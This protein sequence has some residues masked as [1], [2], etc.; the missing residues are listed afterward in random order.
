MGQLGRTL[1]WDILPIC[2][3]RGG[4]YIDPTGD[5]GIDE[6]PYRTTLALT[7]TG[8]EMIDF[9]GDLRNMG[10]KDEEIEKRWKALITILTLEMIPPEKMRFLIAEME[11]SGQG[12][13]SGGVE[14]QVLQHAGT[15]LWVPKS[16][17]RPLR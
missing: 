8:W 7:D 17:M 10:K 1:R 16:W 15:F 12:S 6:W 3:R 5:F 2:M 14:A 11:P 13:S 9:C 4:K